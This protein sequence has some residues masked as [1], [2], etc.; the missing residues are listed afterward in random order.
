[1]ERRWARREKE[2][3]QTS[4]SG[5]MR[6]RIHNTSLNDAVFMYVKTL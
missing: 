1:M 3:E 6:E 5:E 2:G 4:V